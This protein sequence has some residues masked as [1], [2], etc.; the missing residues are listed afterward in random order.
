MAV[1]AQNL[2]GFPQLLHRWSLPFLTYY[3]YSK[4]AH[5][6]KAVKTVIL[7]FMGYDTVKWTQGVLEE[8]TAYI[9]GMQ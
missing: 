2:H 1:R 8:H 4:K 6:F 7:A 5:V 9:G 3:A